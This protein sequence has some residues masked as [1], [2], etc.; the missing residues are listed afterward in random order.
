V[1]EVIGKRPGWRFPGPDLYWDVSI[2][3][4]IP[5]GVEGIAYLTDRAAEQG[6]FTCVPGFHRRIE[7]WLAGLPIGAD[8]RTQDLHALA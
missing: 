2:A 3:T 8:P 1:N 6:A 7:A 5:F 4:P